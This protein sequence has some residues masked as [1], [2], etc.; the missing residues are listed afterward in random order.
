MRP[1]G[2]VVSYVYVH[3]RP[4]RRARGERAPQIKYHAY[5]EL[6]KKLGSSLH[7]HFISDVAN[8]VIRIAKVKFP[9]FGLKPSR[10]GKTGKNIFRLFFMLSFQQKC[11]VRLEYTNLIFGPGPR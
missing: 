4:Q 8:N 7:S 9:I 10:R 6:F 5:M 3:E 2:W 1:L 11:F